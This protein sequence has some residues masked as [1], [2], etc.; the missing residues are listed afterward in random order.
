MNAIEILLNYLDIS[1]F[2]IMIVVILLISVTFLILSS[3]LSDLSDES[4]V[5]KESVSSRENKKDNEVN[6]IINKS[7]LDKS[8]EI[9]GFQQNTINLNGKNFMLSEEIK[10]IENLSQKLTI[11]QS[12]LADKNDELSMMFIESLSSLN[13]WKNNELENKLFKET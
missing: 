9:K 6:H 10:T 12:G 13:S 8:V 2:L 3:D 5:N 11:I 4:K 1:K 7:Q